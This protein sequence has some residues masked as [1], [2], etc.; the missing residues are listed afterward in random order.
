[1]VDN[2]FSTNFFPIVV[3]HRGASDDYPESTLPAYESALDLGVQVIEA[4]VRLSSDGVPVVLHDADLSRVTGGSVTGFVHEMTFAQLSLVELAPGQ[5][6]PGPEGHR[7]PALSEVL[8]LAAGRAGVDLEIKNVPWEPW[9]E[10]GGESILVAALACLGDSGFPGPVLISSFNWPT[11]ERSRE[12]GPEFPTG[13]L[14]VPA[15]PAA[16]ALDYAAEAGHDFVLPN[17]RPLQDAGQEFVDAAHARGVR[18]GTWVVDDE[19][20][21][22]TLFGWGVDA[23]ATD[24]PETAMAVR[25]VFTG[26]A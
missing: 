14:T 24:D 15:M 22:Q 21:I 23:V 13:V 25:R 19:T 16:E 12:I 4:D 5:V 9:Y 10:G 26:E 1:M 11:I 6:A 7:V 18:V 8:A 3:A 2:S 17:E 20:T